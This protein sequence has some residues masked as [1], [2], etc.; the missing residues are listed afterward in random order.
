M[1]TLKQ[2]KALKEVG[3]NGGNISKAMKKAG[4]SDS[5]SKRTDKLTQTK[6]WKELMEQY[7][8]DDMLA[9]KHQELLNSTGIDH[10]VFPLG[11]KGEDDDNFSGGTVDKSKKKDDI[12]VE[13]TTLTDKEI[14]KMLADVN[15]KV[16]RIVHG[17]TARHVY[18]WSADNKARKDGLDMAYKLKGSYA[19]E[20]VDVTA[21]GSIIY[22]PGKK[23]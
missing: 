9:Q 22:L 21:H 10:L 6:G 23:K 15:C 20:K 18:F 4:Y 12:H 3:V 17:E 14:I 2:K 1:A 13:R 8:P 19:S 11:P 5:V 7:L 16:R